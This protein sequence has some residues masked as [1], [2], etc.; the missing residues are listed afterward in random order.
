MPGVWKCLLQELAGFLY[1]TFTTLYGDD[2]LVL[3]AVYMNS[4]GGNIQAL[5]LVS[6]QKDLGENI[7][8]VKA[9]RQQ[10]VE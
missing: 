7:D 5:Q 2:R 1:N 3:W 8:L 6:K 4:K 10:T 9:R